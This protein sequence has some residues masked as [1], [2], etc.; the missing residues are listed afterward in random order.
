MSSG[1]FLA[2]AL[3]LSFVTGMGAFCLVRTL[4]CGA[5]LTGSY[6][7]KVTYSLGFQKA[8]N[9]DLKRDVRV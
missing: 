6:V 2:G 5:C 1:V 7:Y 8:G 3:L 4:D 9:T